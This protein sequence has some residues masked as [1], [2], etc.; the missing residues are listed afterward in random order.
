MEA[1][2]NSF[3]PEKSTFLHPTQYDTLIDGIFPVSRGAIVVL[4]NYLSKSFFAP[5]TFD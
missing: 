5:N 3:D 1:M 4:P 2:S